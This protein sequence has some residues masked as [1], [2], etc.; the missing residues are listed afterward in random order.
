MGS[1]MPVWMWSLPLFVLPVLV[2]MGI[3]LVRRRRLLDMNMVL[4]WFIAVCWII[5]TAVIWVTVR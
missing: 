2:A 3:N 5:A 1:N 4:A